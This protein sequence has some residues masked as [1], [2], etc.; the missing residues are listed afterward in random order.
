[1]RLLA[2]DDAL[3]VNVALHLAVALPPPTLDSKVA[4]MSQVRADHG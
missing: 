3:G 4:E 2:D 1:V